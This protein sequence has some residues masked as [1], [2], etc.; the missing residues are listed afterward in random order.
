MSL[1]LA[2]FNLISRIP[3]LLPCIAFV[4]MRIPL[5]NAHNDEKTQLHKDQTKQQQICTKVMLSSA[6]WVCRDLTITLFHHT[7]KDMV[8][9]CW[10][11]MLSPC[12][13]SLMHCKNPP[14]TL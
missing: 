8:I 11:T 5:G 2:V 6:A 13:Q 9:P 10:Y 1:K 4:S 3:E 7:Y 14:N 12:V